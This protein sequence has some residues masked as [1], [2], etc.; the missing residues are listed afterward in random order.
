MDVTCIIV[1]EVIHDHTP[2]T[3]G[4]LS[5]PLFKQ[6]KHPTYLINVARGAVQVED[7]LLEALDKGLFSKPVAL[8]SW[9]WNCLFRSGISLMNKTVI[10][11]IR[12]YLFPIKEKK[13]AFVDAPRVKDSNYPS[14]K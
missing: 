6:L 12:N 11:S 10:L 8:L 13:V 7:D 14:S 9:Y 2:K 3:K 5:M 1:P 4:L